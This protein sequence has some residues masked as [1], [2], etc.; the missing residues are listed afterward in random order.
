MTEYFRK[1]KI[2]IRNVNKFLSFINS[3]EASLSLLQMVAI[4]AN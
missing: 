1:R 4:F 2:H 3:R